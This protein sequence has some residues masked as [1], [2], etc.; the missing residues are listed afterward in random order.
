MEFRSLVKN[1]PSCLFYFVTR[2]ELAI[3]DY[4]AVEQWFKNNQADYCI[5]CAAFTAVDK[6]ESDMDTAIK[7]NGEAVEHL[8]SV[9]AMYDVKL[10]HFSTDYVFDGTA[11]MPYK[12]Y[13]KIQPVNAYG[14]SKLRG[15]S[16]ALKNNSDSIVIRT[17][18]VYSRYGKNFVNTIIRLLQEKEVISV[19]DD[20]KGNPTYAADLA[21]ACM[22]II[23]DDKFRPGIYHYCNEGVITWFTFASAIKEL[24]GFSCKVLPIPSD[25]YPTAAKRPDYSAL[26][27]EKFKSTFGIGIPGWRESLERCLG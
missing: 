2:D 14:L 16:S 15:E 4:G 12:E 8:A 7:I 9:T 26:N 22:K 25:A 27:T 17:S 10:F 19:V 3:D 23:T 1:Y 6:A 24:K 11:N 13:D 18:W 21:D 5:N 20:Q